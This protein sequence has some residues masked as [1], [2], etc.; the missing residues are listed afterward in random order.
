ME[1]NALFWALAAAYK[2]DFGIAFVLNILSVF[3]EIANPFLI[4]YLI[5]FI[6]DPDASLE[7]GIYLAVAYVLS[8]FFFN[9]SV[10]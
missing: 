10:E 2:K 8:N 5:E 6:Q 9:L 3:F 4:K 7:K 1:T